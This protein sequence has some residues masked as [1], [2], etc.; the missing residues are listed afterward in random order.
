MF[1]LGREEE[2]DREGIVK[3]VLDCYHDD[4][5]G[6]NPNLKLCYFLRTCNYM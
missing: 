4:V 2:M 1:L 5:G 6:P 3:F